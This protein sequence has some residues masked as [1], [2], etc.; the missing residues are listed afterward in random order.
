MVKSPYNWVIYPLTQPKV[1]NQQNKTKKLFLFKQGSVGYFFYFVRVKTVL[2]FCVIN[3]IKRPN[4]TSCQQKYFSFDFI[5]FVLTN[6]FCFIHLNAFNLFQKLMPTYYY[7]IVCCC[8]F[9]PV[10]GCFAHHFLNRFYY[11]FQHF[12]FFFH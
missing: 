6:L 1:T 2:I 3:L 12:H 8:V 4:Q 11:F 9:W 5:H 7:H 10:Q